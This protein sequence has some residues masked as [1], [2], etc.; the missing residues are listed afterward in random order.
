MGTRGAFGFRIDG[1]DKLSY[2]H[3][4]SYPNGLGQSIIDQIKE[5]LATTKLGEM[6]ENVRQIRQID[7]DTEPTQEERERY[8]ALTDG[9][10][11]TG[12]DWY[13]VLRNAQGRVD[14]LL[15]GSLDVMTNGNNFV[16]DSLFCEYAYILDLDTAADRFCL[17]F[18]TGFNKDPEAPGRYAALRDGD[19]QG[20][21]LAAEIPLDRLHTVPTETLVAELDAI[22][23]ARYED[24]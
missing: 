8:A 13:A 21:A 15:D 11:S 23:S 10:V 1:V 12:S 20:V 14:M 17:E 6:I 19:Y 18:Y 24:A 22:A 16:V 7:E 4:D 2:N 9:G 3:F 5:V